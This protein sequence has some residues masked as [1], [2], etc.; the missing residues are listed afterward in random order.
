MRQEPSALPT[1]DFAKVFDEAPAPFL[2]LT[3][4]FVIVHANRARLEATA[5]TLEGTVGR[6]LFDVFPMN[7]DDP[8]ADG[9]R[10]LSASLARA[11]DTKQ[12]VTMPIQ[13]YDIPM[14]DGSYEER[15]WS[16]RNVPILDEDGNVALLLHRSDDITDYVRVRD[17]AARGQQ[18][19]E[20]V[21]QV[22]S[23][24][25]AR[26]RELEGSNAALRAANERERQTALRL[27]GLALTA[28]ALAGAETLED[29]LAR[30][31]EHG[32]PTVGAD[33]AVVALRRGKALD[34]TVTDSSGDRAYSR[35]EPLPLDTH[36]PIGTAA[37]GEAVIVHDRAELRERYGD[38]AVH[39]SPAPE[40]EAWAVLPLRAGDQLLGSLALGWRQPQAFDQDDVRLLHAFAAQCA[41][42]VDR[43][44]RLQAERQQAKATR[45]LAETLQR[46]LLTDPPQPDHLEIAVRYLPAAQEAQVGGDWYDAF[47]SP[48]GTTTLAIG[49]VTGHD[50]TAAAAMGQLRNLLRGIAF[51]GSYTP[52]GLLTTLDGAVRQL[53][54]DALATAVVARVEQTLEERRA[55]LRTLRWSNAGHP[56]PLLAEATGE[57]SVL[58]RPA[59]LL[60]GLAPD[61]PRADYSVTLAPGSTVVLYTDGLVERRGEALDVGLERLAEA[62]RRLHS[63]PLELLCEAL[64]AELAPGADDDIALVALRAHPEDRPRPVRRSGPEARAR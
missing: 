34:L 16:P 30:L 25:F 19:R 49:D 36:M 63:L 22:E 48:D 43:V 7:P 64:L 26:T 37:R 56:P 20:R 35:G 10:N 13:K 62:V 44:T 50:R 6:N 5:T 12:P 58:E 45:S 33:T 29:V 2:L 21:E 8:A 59:D 23:D 51:A 39:M 17:E 38:D 1:P 55:G 53:G 14:P 11:R 15:Y 4:D 46:S 28:S 61:V 42:A 31:F 18:W 47:L 3:P 54:L 9:L 60:L 57:V 32:R 40:L 24:L 27:A 41:Q 52:A